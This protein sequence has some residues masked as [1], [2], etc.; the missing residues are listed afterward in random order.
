MARHPFGEHFIMMPGWR[1]SPGKGNGNPLPYLCLENPYRQK[2]L[3]GYGPW[4]CKESDTTEELST[5]QPRG[6]RKRGR[7][8]R[9]RRG[10]SPMV[11]SGF[12]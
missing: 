10:E 11:F 4:G 3:E 9:G 8:R 5:E 2:S 1:K 6:G 7:R 12:Y